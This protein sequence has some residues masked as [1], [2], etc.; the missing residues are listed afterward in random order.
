MEE[1]LIKHFE[2][3]KEANQELMAA[4]QRQISGEPGHLEALKLFEKNTD[5]EEEESSG[6]P[7]KT[8]EE[9]EATMQA[10]IASSPFAVDVASAHAKLLEV[11]GK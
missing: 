3:V 10:H 6:I 1:K 2:A 4:L 7:A 9:V 11:M 8:D 5:G